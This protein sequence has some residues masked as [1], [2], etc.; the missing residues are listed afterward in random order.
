[1][2]HAEQLLFSCLVNISLKHLMF[3]PRI[4][5]S[6]WKVGIGATWWTPPRRTGSDMQ[7]PPSRTGSNWQSPPVAPIPT[8]HGLYSKARQSWEL[9]H[10]LKLFHLPVPR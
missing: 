7:I 2:G 6:P 1:M 4:L 9:N 8:F 10:F 5:Y 3:Y